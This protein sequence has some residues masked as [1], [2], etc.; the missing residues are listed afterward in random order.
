MTAF[1][2]PDGSD[3]L[4]KTLHLTLV[5]HPDCLYIRVDDEP[6]RTDARD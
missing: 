1:V 6:R 3:P 5:V 4:I 2:N